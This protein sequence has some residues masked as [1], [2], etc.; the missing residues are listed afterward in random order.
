MFY[1]YSDIQI[2]QDQK[3]LEPVTEDY[4]LIQNPTYVKS[5]TKNVKPVKDQKPVIVLKTPP[6]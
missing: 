3:L 2:I 1:K 4:S 5:V 6:H